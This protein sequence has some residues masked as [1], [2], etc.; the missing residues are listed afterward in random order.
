M[1]QSPDKNF[2]NVFNVG[3]F[4]Q[5]RYCVYVDPLS[6]P[7]NIFLAEWSLRQKHKTCLVSCYSKELWTFSLSE[8]VNPSVPDSVYGLK[9]IST[10]SFLPSTLT[11]SETTSPQAF[12]APYVPLILAI[13]GLIT[14]NLTADYDYI[15][16][17]SMFVSP[18]QVLAHFNLRLMASGTLL[19]T[20]HYQRTQIMR[21][22]SAPELPM[23]DT[24]LIIAPS[25]SHGAFVSVTDAPPQDAATIISNIYMSSGYRVLNDE[26]WCNV[27]VDGSPAACSWPTELCFFFPPWKSSDDLRDLEWY[28]VGDALD[29]VEKLI[30]GFSRPPGDMS[31]IAM[32]A[33][34]Y[35]RT[36]GNVY[37]TPPD[38]QNQ[39]RM[40]NESAANNWSTPSGE[41]SDY[42]LASQWGGVDDEGDP[43]PRIGGPDEDVLM[44]GDTEEVTEADF[45]FFDDDGNSP[46]SKFFSENN[47]MGNEFL[48]QNLHS[49]D[50]ENMSELTNINVEEGPYRYKV[51]D[52][53]M[54]RQQSKEKQN[55]DKI[56]TPPLSP[57]TVLP[58]EGTK[59]SLTR[60]RK[61][62]FT[63]L[64]F[65]PNLES[66]LDN[67]Y[68]MGG[69]FY[70]SQDE[71]D[72]SESED[73][74]SVSDNERSDYQDGKTPRSEREEDRREQKR[75]GEMLS[76]DTS[77]DAYVSR[78]LWW[79]LLVTTRHTRDDLLISSVQPSASRLTQSFIRKSAEYTS[80]E[81]DQLLQ[82]LCES[83]VWDS[84]VLFCFLPPL[85]A[86]GVCGPDFVN[87]LKEIFG[88]IQS[89]HLSDF[90]PLADSNNALTSYQ[91]FQ[92][93]VTDPSV[94]SQNA[95]NNFMFQVDLFCMGNAA[96]DTA[97]SKPDGPIIKQKT[98]KSIFYA[99]PP[100]FSFIRLNTA[101]EA[102][103]PALR[104]WNVFG[105]EPQSGKKNL[106]SFIMH[107]GSPGMASAASA[108]MNRFKPVYE[109]CNL[110]S[111]SMGE[112]GNYKNGLVPLNY[113]GK[114]VSEAL[115]EMRKTFVLLGRLLYR[116]AN[117]STNVLILLATP[118]SDPSSLLF[119]CQ[120]FD[121]LKQEFAALVGSPVESCCANLVFQILPV[122]FFA[123]KECIVVPS[124]YSLV[125][126]ALTLYDKCPISVDPSINGSH[127]SAYTLARS[128]PSTIEYKLTA[129]PS[130]SLFSEN[131]YV[132]IAYARS[133]DRKFVTA[134]WADQYGELA[135]IK[136]MSL[137]RNDCA[138]PRS[139]EELCTEIWER[140]LALL[141]EMNIHWRLVFTKVG[142]MEAEELN[143]W[144]NLASHT[145]ENVLAMFLC[146]DTNPNV[147][148]GETADT[149]FLN[150]N[151]SIY[152]S[153]ESLQRHPESP[154]DLY[155]ASSTTPV[156]PGDHETP[157]SGATPT[158][159]PGQSI[160]VPVGGGSGAGVS[161][162]GASANITT[163]LD[164]NALLVDLQ[165]ETFGVVVNH[166]LQ[167]DQ[168]D[169]AGLRFSLAS[170]F[171]L[172]PG[173]N[174]V[175]MSCLQV[176][177][178]NGPKP[179]D[180]VLE[181][182][183]RQYR[184]MASYGACTGVLDGR[185]SVLPWHVAAVEKMQRIISFI[186]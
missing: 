162:S 52:S 94:H 181:T 55:P 95:M 70:V 133:R 107:P 11:M 34:A 63:P 37:P 178:L 137:A 176:S 20:P 54:Q 139:D 119:I 111:F 168:Y 179:W 140:T 33:S 58:S 147:T 153:P 85:P 9:E 68:S 141:P 14:R 143:V 93:T 177:L 86:V 127:L 121:Q 22:S 78:Q 150:R 40:T 28:K 109:G 71:S 60:K 145:K 122:N 84:S 142:V 79:V 62:V 8:G 123:S 110:G 99:P 104:F 166:R 43:E 183:L 180:D 138:R 175:L 102:L 160:P 105:F 167:L 77:S 27:I 6:R 135:T 3:N 118:F 165:D 21:L 36:P 38:P 151:S 18:S 186:L 31:P 125:K 56:I 124:Q 45:N 159:T 75:V 155:G 116:Y 76:D 164:Q 103:P 5:I 146:V 131:S 46:N 100:L 44:I 120:G 64:T 113:S 115:D 144:L 98:A 126:F 25:G 158:S 2:T 112:V 32:P 173:T 130:S 61:G 161:G 65:Y 184:N 16:I 149:S 50:I 66:A 7:V 42:P 69:R 171:L 23:I 4:E 96:P 72:D 154:M 73:E 35:R 128:Y 174:G 51:E 117:S 47:Q 12:P 13:S 152:S 10:G 74:N 59:G 134:A 88:S 169:V 92:D 87:V 82:S 80:A 26:S 67:K 1:A 156:M 24:R 91:N 148:V 29:D 172:K 49:F 57:L 30:I 48:D 83:V 101:L 157:A 108:F 97:S 132:H 53:E 182:V 170:G 185:N 17:G 19:I 81:M 114:S 90:A 15:P 129:T 89:L 41:R 106:L 136:V 163:A 39:N